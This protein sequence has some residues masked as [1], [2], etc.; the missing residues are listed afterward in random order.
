LASDRALRRPDRRASPRDELCAADVVTRASAV[1]RRSEEL[2]RS[3]ERFSEE[4][5]GVRAG[6]A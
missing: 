2:G 5:L 6:A 3:V 4:L 1:A